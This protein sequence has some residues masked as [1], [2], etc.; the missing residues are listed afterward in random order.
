M[1]NGKRSA[2]C[3]FQAF[4]VVACSNCLLSAQLQPPGTSTTYPLMW[5]LPRLQVI[6]HF[7]IRHEKHFCK[8]ARHH[9]VIALKSLH[10]LHSWV[11]MK[12]FKARP[13]SIFKMSILENV[14]STESHRSFN[15]APWKFPGFP[16]AFW[17]ASDQWVSHSRYHRVGGMIWSHFFPS[18]VKHWKSGII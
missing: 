9:S 18:E 10:V 3:E 13:L 4:V 6:L 14:D 7:Q 1:G 12:F 15:F 2:G 5:I 11:K 16:V 8:C 17:I